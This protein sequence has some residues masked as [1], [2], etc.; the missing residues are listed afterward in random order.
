M[1]DDRL[2]TLDKDALLNL[3]DDPSPVVRKEL[4]KAFDSLGSTGLELLKDAVEGP[5]RLLG[6]HASTYLSELQ[7]ANP[8]E[9]FR[10]FIRSMN[11]E[12]ES[13]W[14]M[15]SRVAYPTI[16]IGSI[17]SE[18][19]QIAARCKE[20]IVRPASTRD[21]CL[22]INRVLFHELG[23][24]GNTENYT[25][26]ENSFINRVLQ[27]RKGLPISLSALYLL[28]AERLGAALEPISAP[29]H[30]VIGCFE[31]SVPFYVDSFD[32]GRILT[33]GQ[34]LKRVEANCME[35]NLSH[36][37][38]SSSRETLSRICRN[39][40]DHYTRSDHNGMA[41]LFQSF[42]QEFEDAYKKRV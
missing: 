27:T 15:I 41:N 5:N 30:F 40:V 13:G 23:F 36:L 32:H 42:L 9:E 29:G 7:N 18:L 6:W 20:L 14:I 1:Q 24:R 21:Q 2:T 26:P 22:V 8:S 10:T 34:M 31:E 38:P 25:D 11:Y 3:L 4:L 39:L 19:D 12:L 35:P 17:C 16:D 37:A 28:V 33:A